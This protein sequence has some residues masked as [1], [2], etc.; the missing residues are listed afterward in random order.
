MPHFKDSQNKLHWLDDAAHAHML[1]AGCVEITDAEADVLRAPPPP[2]PEQLREQAKAARA[3]AVAAIDVTVTSGKTFDGD[4]D[5]QTR[6][7]RAILGMQA[8]AVPTITWTLA[9]NT[10]AEVTVA[11]LTEA[12]IL[13]GQQQ[14]A[15]WPIP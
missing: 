8:A 11:E 3:A 6:M 12:L 9:D 2:T 1:P 4:E 7:A 10:I 13:A 15:L 14:A 5:S